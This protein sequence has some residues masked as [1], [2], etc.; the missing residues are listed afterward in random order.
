[1]AICV[2]ILQS[3]IG[4]KRFTSPPPIP[5]T[6]IALYNFQREIQ[7]QRSTNSF[8]DRGRRGVASDIGVERMGDGAG[9][10]GVGGHQRDFADPLGPERTF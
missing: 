8:P 5:D 9:Y 7:N 4:F 1:M 10:G 6:Q 2:Q 3:N